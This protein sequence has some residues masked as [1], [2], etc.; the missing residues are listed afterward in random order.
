MSRTDL[1][2]INYGIPSKL[3][4]R[5]LEQDKKLVQHNPICQICK[6]NPST[7]VTGLGTLKACCETCNDNIYKA[8]EED[9][10]L[11]QKVN[12]ELGYTDEYGNYL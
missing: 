4:E 5:L 12:F 1:A 11:S 7:R 10:K 2:Y 9:I 8:I 6:E 3:F